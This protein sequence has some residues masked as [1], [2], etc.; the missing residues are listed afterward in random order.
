MALINCPFCGKQISDKAVNC[1]HCGKY[2]YKTN[3]TKKLFKFHAKRV[4]VPL[5][6]CALWGLYFAEIF[7]FNSFFHEF[8]NSGDFDTYTHIGLSISSVV[9]SILLVFLESDGI[10]IATQILFFS[11][12]TLSLTMLGFKIEEECHPK[13]AYH[14]F[15]KGVRCEQKKDHDNAIVWYRI[16]ADNGNS[17]ACLQ[18]GYLYDDGL[19]VK[20]DYETALR[21]YQKVMQCT[22]PDPYAVAI[23]YNNIG[24]MYQT[25]RG[26]KKDL[27]KAMEFF[28]LALKIIDG[29]PYCFEDEYGAKLKNKIKKHIKEIVETSAN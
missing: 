19:G 20:Q 8:G 15:I 14:Q 6:V 29:A 7:P 12:V 2:V 17:N 1:P 18:M 21:W 26:V 4:C 23:A 16:A 5:V 11:V 24:Y 13:E 10:R 25:G 28:Q 3:V 27:H 22:Y 9:L